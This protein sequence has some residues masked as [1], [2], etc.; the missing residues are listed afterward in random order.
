M[1]KERPYVQFDLCKSCICYN[2]IDMEYVK[3]VRAIRPLTEEDSRLEAPDFATLALLLVVLSTLG[4]M[5]V[6]LTIN[7]ALIHACG[8][9]F[10]T[11][12]LML[13]VYC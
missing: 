4:Q 5:V 3:A 9:P 13:P 10:V 2:S 12:V 6:A 8:S 1:T 11:V 7:D